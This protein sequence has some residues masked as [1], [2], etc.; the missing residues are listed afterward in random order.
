MQN[1]AG[2]IYSVS[3]TR[4][5]DD[6]VNKTLELKRAKDAAES[7][8]KAKSSFLFNMSHDIRTPLNAIM[9]VFRNGDAAYGRQCQAER[10]PQKD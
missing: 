1:S 4:C 6:D 8:N 9:G 5:I 2:D 7:A 3:M 10:L